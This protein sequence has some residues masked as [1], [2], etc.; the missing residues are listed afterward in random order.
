[1]DATLATHV[2]GPDRPL[3]VA[4][5]GYRSNPFSG[6]QGVYLKHLSKALVDLGHSVDV[7]SG[8]PYPDLDPRVGLVKLAGLNLYEHPK[9]IRALAQGRWMDPIN[10]FEWLSFLSKSYMYFTAHKPI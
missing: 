2:P 10:L 8:E 9:P 5:L 7:I 4:L 6:G 1:M 3:K